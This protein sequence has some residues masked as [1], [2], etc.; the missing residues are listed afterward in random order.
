MKA[1]PKRFGLAFC[2]FIAF[3]CSFSLSAPRCTAAWPKD[4]HFRLAEVNGRPCLV[5][6]DGKPFK[7]VGMVWA[8]GPEEGP[9][10]REVTPEVIIEELKTMQSLGF[11]TLNLYGARFI[12]EMLDWCDAHELAVYFRTEYYYLP[13]FPSTLREYPDYMDPAFREMVK[14]GF[15]SFLAQVKDHPSVLAIDMDH[16]WLFPL[17]WSGAQRR[18][19]PQL[20]THAVAFFQKWLRNRYHTID[21]LNAAWATAYES[22]E[23]ILQDET[24][25]TGGVF[26]KLGCHPARVDVVRYTLWTAVDFLT[27]LTAYI[28]ERA[29]GVMI[30]LTTEHPECLPEINPGKESGIAFMSPVHYNGKD[31]YTRDLPSLCKLI[32]ERRIISIFLQ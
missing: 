2:L 9:H 26:Q 31:D 25:L 29:P 22:F 23:A 11:N 7:S 17:D 32:Y 15:D 10:K 30:T 6:P 19:Q 24:L 18:D 4:T 27:E 20:R 1:E 13:E 5:A 21:L 8:Y 14:T 16:R 3:L 28:H 12:P